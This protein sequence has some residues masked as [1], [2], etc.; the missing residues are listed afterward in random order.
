MTERD[1]NIGERCSVVAIPEEGYDFVN[2]TED[3]VQVSTDNPYRFDVE[4]D[5]NLIANFQPRQAQT[6]NIIVKAY[7]NNSSGTITGG[8]TYQQNQTCT[9]TATANT[10]YTFTRWTKNGTQ[11]SINNPYSFTVTGGGTYTAVF[12]STQVMID[13][14][15]KPEGAG[16]VSGVGNYNIGGECTLTATPNTGYEF[17]EWQENEQVVS[18]DN[19]Y[20]FTVGNTN[21][22]LIANFT[23]TTPRYTVTTGVSYSGSIPLSEGVSQ[24]SIGTV[25]GDDGTPKLENTR[26]E[27]LAQASNGFEFDGWDTTM[28]IHGN[29]NPLTFTLTEDT[30]CIAR[31]KPEYELTMEIVGSGDVRTTY[32]GDN[33]YT[34][35]ASPR[36]GYNFT[37]WF[38]VTGTGGA[39]RETEIHPTGDDPT[40]LERYQISGDTLIRARFSQA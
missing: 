22:T 37:G 21:R 39:E 19:P 5:R 31:F 34:A 28:D 14:E 10:G 24:N 29:T 2:W 25:T 38:L 33:R 20:T 12:T 17:V 40:V 1:F 26:I 18:S 8:G 9:L 27:L 11:V 32:D 4:R 23:T 35:A 15:I 3:G 13:A 36:S 7:P 6:Y 30:R 16:S